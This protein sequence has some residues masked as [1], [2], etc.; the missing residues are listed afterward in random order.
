MSP[1]AP[2]DFPVTSGASAC[3]DRLHDCRCV[4]QADHVQ[5]H[6]CVVPGCGALWTQSGSIV[7]LPIKQELPRRFDR[8][9]LRAA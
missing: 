4:W 7:R 3:R 8:A 1:E 9:D 6:M 2:E 5:L